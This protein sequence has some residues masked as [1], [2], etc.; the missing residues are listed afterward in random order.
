MKK[1]IEAGDCFITSNIIYV[2][3]DKIIECTFHTIDLPSE[4]WMESV[5]DI[6]D[7]YEGETFLFNCFKDIK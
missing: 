2:A 3:N 1:K 6:G 4:E 5:G 7:D